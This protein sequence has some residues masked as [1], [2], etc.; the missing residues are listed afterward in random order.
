MKV[1]L[2]ERAGGL[3]K[4]W[5]QPLLVHPFTKLISPS[6]LQGRCRAK[7]RAAQMRT[8]LERCPAQCREGWV[9]SQCSGLEVKGMDVVTIPGSAWCMQ[10]ALYCCLGHRAF[11]P[12]PQNICTDFSGSSLSL[13]LLLV[14]PL[15]LTCCLE[16]LC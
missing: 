10:G 7:A 9:W 13:F 8:L 2:S 11:D 12:V 16:D 15:C 4:H 5:Q 14:V 1:A 3:E 6:C